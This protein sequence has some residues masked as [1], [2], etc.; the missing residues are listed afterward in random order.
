M[1]KEE[2]VSSSRASR[3]LN[4][5]RSQLYYH[6]KRD[7]S[8]VIIKLQELADKYPSKGLDTY[9]K[10]IQRQGLRWGRMRVLRVYRLMKLGM[11]RK[12]K[13]RLPARVKEPLKSGET[14]NTQWAMDFMSDALSNG[15][16]IRILN[17]MDECSREALAV[18]ADYSIPS[19]VVTQQLEMLE[20]ERGLPEVIRVDN[21]P[22]YTSQEFA[23]WCQKKAIRIHYIQPGRPMQNAFMERF[24]KTFRQ[25]VLD[26][27]L[28]DS[29]EEINQLAEQ[30]M[31][32]YNHELPHGS[33][34]NMTPNEYAQAV[35]SGKLATHKPNTE[36]TTI[37]SHN[38]SSPFLKNSLV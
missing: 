21:G 18:Y 31:W 2:P 14:I 32:T 6:S 4:L 23:E 8:E 12:G 37:N 26:A 30:W 9:F 35:N 25:D 22:E 33:L 10:L 7:D 28:V 27:Y 5:P 16:R 1:T 13:R 20:K 24:N 19:V 17:I 29:I 15:R 3:V 36:F 34:N 38:S 11:R